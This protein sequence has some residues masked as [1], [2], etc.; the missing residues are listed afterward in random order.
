M[1][2]VTIISLSQVVSLLCL[3]EGSIMFSY[4]RIQPKTRTSKFGQMLQATHLINRNIL[5][6]RSYRLNKV[7]KYNDP[8]F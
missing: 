8:M 1:C 7:F 2:V 4:R 6:D 5:F 3:M